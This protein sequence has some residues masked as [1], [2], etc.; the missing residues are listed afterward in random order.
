MAKHPNKGRIATLAAMAAVVALPAPGLAQGGGQT[1]PRTL[2]S[3]VASGYDDP[4]PGFLDTRLRSRDRAPR[5]ARLRTGQT[6]LRRALG[7]TGVVDVDPVTG[8]PRRVARLN[9]F[10]TGPS[11]RSATAI[12]L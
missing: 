5:S 9:G 11:R 12:A 1:R 3:P 6:R 7:R 2:D 4:K 10:L 8:T